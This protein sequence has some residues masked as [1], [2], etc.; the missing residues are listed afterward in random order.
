MTIDL[1]ELAS[2]CKPYDSALLDY[3]ETKNQEEVY[4]TYGQ[5]NGCVNETARKLGKDAG[6]VSK[7]IRNLQR[8]AGLA[9]YAPNINAEPLVPTSEQVKG[10]SIFTTDEHGNRIWIKTE[11]SVEEQQKALKTYIDALCKEIKPAKKKPPFKKK[12]DSLLMAAIFIGDAHIG[13]YAYGKETKHRDFDTDTAAEGLREAID[14][15]IDRAPPAETL[16]LVDVGDFMHQ[17]S[18]HNKTW[19]G[20]DLDTDTRYSRV[21]RTAGQVMNYAVNRALEKFKKVVVVIARGNH[22]EDPAVAVQEIVSAWWRNEPRV[23]VLDTDGRFH[24]IEWGNWLIGVNHGDKIKP[25]KL[26]NVMARDMAA[27]W[28]RT[29]HR[30]WATGHFHHEQVLE[31]DGCTVHR[32]G[33][34]PPPDAWHASSGFGGD[35]QMQMMVFRKEGGKHSTL[36]YDTIRPQIEPDRILV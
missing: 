11:K 21:L 35:G 14:N 18:S 23:D 33:A 3:C 8:K 13:M 30:M 7:T 22:N 17:N 20:T 15:L 2:R 6:T 31:K 24:Y 28:G 25:D 36:I 34:L 1:Y 32:F 29:T 16:L 9:G 10:R 27:A 4:E 12:L 5:S 19:S 26:V